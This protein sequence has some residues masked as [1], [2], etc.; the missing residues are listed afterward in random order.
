[1]MRRASALALILLAG[2]NSIAG[3]G[4]Y[5]AGAGDAGSDAP[6]APTCNDPEVSLRIAVLGSVSGDFYGITEVKGL[7]AE[8]DVGHVFAECVPAGTGIELH[9]LPGDPSD[10][11]HDWGT[12]GQ[13]RHCAMTVFSA[14]DLEVELQ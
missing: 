13:G 10:A 1:M 7:F 9:A 8:L 6:V 5:H 11:V 14:T 4:D 2:C 3:I 12:C